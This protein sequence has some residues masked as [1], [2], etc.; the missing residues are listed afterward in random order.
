MAKFRLWNDGEEMRFGDELVVGSSWVQKI[1]FR[2]FKELSIGVYG[3]HIPLI[4]SELKVIYS[5]LLSGIRI[6]MSNWNIFMFLRPK[7]LFYD[8]VSNT[9]FEESFK[10]YRM[11]CMFIKFDEKWEKY[12]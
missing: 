1:C 4:W 10:G 3:H 7:I 9:S 11:M 6:Y 8:I 2:A 5:K 12:K